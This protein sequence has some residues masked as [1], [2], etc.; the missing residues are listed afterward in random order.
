MNKTPILDELRITIEGAVALFDAEP[1]EDHPDPIDD[2]IELV[3][4]AESLLPEA[5]KRLI[6]IPEAGPGDE[7]GENDRR[8]GWARDVVDQFVHKT[9]TDQP[10]AL[11]DLLCD[12]QHYANAYGF[13]FARE[14]R[15]ACDHFAAETANAPA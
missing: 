8:A 9:G 15:R 3:R 1:D 13:D 5:G 7:D 14:L 4:E 11:C 12:L 2:A 10:D 6:E